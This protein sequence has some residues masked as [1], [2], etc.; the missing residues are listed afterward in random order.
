MNPFELPQEHFLARKE[1][2]LS[3][4]E[5]RLLATAQFIHESYADRD[6]LLDAWNFSSVDLLS[7]PSSRLD[8]IGKVGYFPWAEASTELDQALNLLMFGYYKSAH[9]SLRRALELVITGSFF[10]LDNVER[11]K[12]LGWIRS[13]Q[14]TP[15]FKRAVIH[16]LKEPVFKSC[17]DECGW[18]QYVLDQYWRLCDVIHVRG[19][20]NS[21]SEISPS[22]AIINGINCPCFHK[23][24]CEKVLGAFIQTVQ[25]I[26]STV[27]LSNPV[28]L[29]GF[30]L[31]SK[32]GLNTPQSG[33]F[34]PGQ[35]ELLQ[36][37][38]VTQFQDFISHLVETDERIQSTI[39]WFNALSDIT[40][41]DFKAQAKAMDFS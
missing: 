29:V 27:A 30:D 31:D 8:H 18:K 32:F 38:I 41:E 23:D 1:I 33:F 26:A 17:N 35:A 20:K 9:D 12:A 14:G 7:A 22:F 19:I 4:V 15:N 25:A 5:D 10:V 6:L 16:L 40:A 28:L 21:F 39:A 37:H 36:R 13:E 34:Y 2:L 11:K 3:G 24:S